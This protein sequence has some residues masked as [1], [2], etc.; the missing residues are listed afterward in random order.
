MHFV[1]YNCLLNDSQLC[2][3][4][5]I[6]SISADKTNMKAYFKGLVLGSVLMYWYLNFS[7]G[8]L[9]EFQHWFTAVR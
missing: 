1:L 2:A 9:A 6:F 5:K 3:T 4:V 7:A 8:F